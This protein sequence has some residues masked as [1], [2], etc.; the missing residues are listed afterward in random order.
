MNIKH[1]QSDLND[2][3]SVADDI[4]NLIQ[5]HNATDEETVSLLE[6]INDCAKIIKEL[7]QPPQGSIERMF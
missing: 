6:E 5:A 3:F 4:I 1:L 2:I 7:S